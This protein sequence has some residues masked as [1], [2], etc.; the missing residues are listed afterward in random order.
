[1][2]MLLLTTVVTCG[3]AALSAA[4]ALTAFRR[5][6]RALVLAER[7]AEAREEL[8]E[9]SRDLDAATERTNELA[10]RVAWL[11]AR[12]SAGLAPAAPAAAEGERAR[13]SKPHITE[14]RHRVLMLA[15]RG[16]NPDIIAATLNM[17]RGEVELI[18]GMS[19]AA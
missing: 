8:C 7:L 9:L 16:Q 10:R 5:S 12:R 4:C 13:P 15:R 11:E 3:A 2:L 1:M 17:T 18:I 19:R 14:R 6:R